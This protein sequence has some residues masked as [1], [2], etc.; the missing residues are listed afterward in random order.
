[1]IRRYFIAGLLVWVPLLVTLFIIRF[2]VNLIDSSLSFLPVA[3]Q[4]DQW[5]GT[6]LPGIGLLV[7]LL[8]LFFT[9][10][11]ATNFLGR[12]LVAM[13][14]KLLD[15]IP[16]VRTIYNAAKQVMNSLFNPAADAFRKVLLIEYPRA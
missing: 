11:I 1:M 6:H 10:V 5:F 14:E 7:A 3:Y 9:G 16:L 4:P 12:R 8:I 2:I 15:K 13:C